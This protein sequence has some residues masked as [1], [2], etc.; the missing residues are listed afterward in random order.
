MDDKNKNIDEHFVGDELISNK[1]DDLDAG[2]NLQDE[3][4]DLSED[5][6]QL[7]F[8]LDEDNKDDNGVEMKK[9]DKDDKDSKTKEDEVVTINKS[10]RKSVV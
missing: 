3:L 1:V 9:E 6:E 8:D 7:G 2:N 10:D 5:E 4:N